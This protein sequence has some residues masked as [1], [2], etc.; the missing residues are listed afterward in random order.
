[1]HAVFIELP[2]KVVD[3]IGHILLEAGF[4]VGCFGT[5]MVQ[6]ERVGDISD[7]EKTTLTKKMAEELFVFEND[8]DEDD[9]D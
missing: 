9:D 4:E 8:D 1:M 7:E 5:G 2:N 3:L 6:M